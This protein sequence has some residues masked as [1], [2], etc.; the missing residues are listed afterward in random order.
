VA[1]ETPIVADGVLALRARHSGPGG[2]EAEAELV[3][4]FS[5]RVRLYGLK[6]LRDSAAAADLVQDT[7]LTTI[8]A[9][10][11]GRVR[12]P[13]KI[14]SFIL[15]T[16]R[17]LARDTRRGQRRRDKLQEGLGHECPVDQPQATESRDCERVRE[18]LE[19]LDQREKNILI[20]TFFAEKDAGA[21]A[22]ELG[23]SPGN[24]RVIRHRALA[25]LKQVITGEA[26]S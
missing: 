20:L 24:V 2:A 18:A 11:A 16:A 19:H 7:L 23:L 9:L 3:R 14:A 21:I 25:R 8:Q 4:R 13:E 12:E 1:D 26:E 15:G 10:R 17:M 6:H 22:A 5:P